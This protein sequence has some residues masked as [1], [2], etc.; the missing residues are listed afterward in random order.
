MDLTV[1][2]MEARGKLKEL[3]KATGGA[4]GSIGVDYQFEL[5]LLNIFGEDF[6][7]DF[8]QNK[9][10]SWLELLSLFETKKRSFSPHKQHSVNISLPFSFIEYYREKSGMSI[11]AAIR[12][13][14]DTR[15]QWTH[16]GML[17][18]LPSVMM[19]LFEP[20]I[21]AIIHHIQDLLLIPQ[22]SNVQY[23]FLVGGFAESAVLQDAV[24]NA[25]RS[26]IRVII[27][28]DVSLTILKGAVL[29]GHDPTL[30]QIRRSVLTYGVGC[31]N[32]FI[33]GEHPP[34][35]R[36][37]KDGVEWCTGIFDAFIFSDQAVSLGDMITR[38][39]SPAQ[40]GQRSTIISLFA[41]EKDAVYFVSDLG[42]SKVGELKLE[43]PDTT[44][45]K[46]RELRMSMIFGD[47]E[48]SVEAVDI[49][50][51]RT[52]HASIDFLNK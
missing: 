49:T 22:L 46:Q 4:W 34:E 2:E 5:L 41:S 38:S 30:V 8:V 6:L 21:S 33:P 20:V 24:R 1:H 7:L 47:T 16:Q 17:R 10:V 45:G 14:N 51:G 40:A 18:L 11:E 26:N 19:S 42:C 27:P 52:A 44:G 15:V 35:K 29:F 23:L 13:Y 3:Y 25:F 32:R 37:I 48:I 43:M 36:I 39:Y 31:L 12:E 28:Q 9:P 50:S